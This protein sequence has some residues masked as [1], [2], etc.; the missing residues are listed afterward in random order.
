MIAGEKLIAH[1]GVFNNTTIPENSIASFKKAIELFLPFEL[2]VQLTKDR[3]LVVFHDDNLKRMCGI[4][5]KIK[6]MTYDE[7]RNYKL[8]ETEEIIPRLVDVLRLT[9]DIR[10][11]DI[12][13]KNTNRIQETVTELMNCISGYTNITIK[14]F[15]P[16][17]VKA[18]KKRNPKL[19]VGLLITDNY[20]NFIY[21]LFLR[22][23]LSINLC[24]P[25]F[26]S[27]SEKL[28]KTD[29]FRN[30]SK[31]IPTEV[32]TIKY[33]SDVDYNNE[34]TYICENLPYVR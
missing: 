4:D 25:D 33:S 17:I 15:S 6:D 22:G 32:W 13:V 14:S 3:I 24:K 12:E 20:N 5:K 7:I 2:D 1:R 8:L 9:N 31:S 23:K 26:I 19:K 34:I 18:V 27:I 10:L 28:Y 30:I 21:N 16:K 29:K 11:I